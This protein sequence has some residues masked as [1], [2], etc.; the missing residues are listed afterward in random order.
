MSKTALLTEGVKHFVTLIEN[1]VFDIFQVQGSVT[2]QSLET[3]WSCDDNMRWVLLQCFL[4]LID[5]HTTKKDSNLKSSAS[6]VKN[7]AWLVL[8]LEIKKKKS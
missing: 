1:K 2:D 6:I 7:V 3:T 5:W 8:I 4:V